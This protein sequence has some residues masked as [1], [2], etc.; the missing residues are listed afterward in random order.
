[1]RRQI[2]ADELADLFHQAGKCLWHLLY[3]EHALQHLLVLKVDLA[4]GTGR[5][6]QQVEEFLE[7]RRGATLGNAIRD[8]EKNEVLPSS[9]LKTLRNLK[10]ERDWLIH[11]A[12]NQH[13]DALYTSEGRDLVFSRLKKLAQDAIDLQLSVAKHSLRGLDPVKIES[14]AQQ[15]LADFKGEP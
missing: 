6:Q 5:T 13:G 12:L 15:K 1:M 4:Q 2:S 9:L 7:K 14:T 10:G 11:K 8:A 3:L